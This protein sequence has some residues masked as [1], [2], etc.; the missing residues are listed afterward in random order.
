MNMN[1]RSV[2]VGSFAEEVLPHL[3]SAYNLAR[4]LVGNADDA[5]DVVQ[6]AYLRAFRYYDGF[7]GGNARAWL[8]TIVR[9]T[10]Y[11]WL[12]KNRTQQAADEFDETIHS[13]SGTTTPEA[14]ML[15]DAD[16]RMVEQALNALPPRSR[17]VLVL[18]E[19]EGLAYKEIAGVIGVPIGTV[20]SS[21][22]RARERFRRSVIEQ[23][24]SA[25]TAGPA[26]R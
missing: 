1:E 22:S 18:R 8:L 9:N 26:G 11:R 13:G 25:L 17:E 24:S 16:S 14:L 2:P 19:L 4:W 5:D 10:S 21:L 3:D 6:D 15:R 7:Q 20:M 12:Q 23:L